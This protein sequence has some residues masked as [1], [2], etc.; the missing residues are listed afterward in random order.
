[1][2]IW[3]QTDFDKAD[4]KQFL[5]IEGSPRSECENF[6]NDFIYNFVLVFVFGA[7]KQKLMNSRK[8][9]RSTI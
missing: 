2:K 5:N 7:S 6:H 9:T 8:L 1:M 3:T 4:L